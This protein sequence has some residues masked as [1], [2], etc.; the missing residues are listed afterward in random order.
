MF[1]KIRADANLVALD[2]CGD[3]AECRFPISATSTESRRPWF[4][5]LGAPEIPPAPVAKQSV[6]FGRLALVVAAAGRRE[7]LVRRKNG[8]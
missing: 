1:R 8:V 5:W 3:F 7:N 4:I 6:L 2:H